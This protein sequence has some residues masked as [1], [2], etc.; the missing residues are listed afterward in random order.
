MNHYFFK[1]LLI[2]ILVSI[3]F[4]LFYKTDKNITIKIPAYTLFKPIPTELVPEKKEDKLVEPKKERTPVT[5]IFINLEKIANS[6]KVTLENVTERFIMNR[7]IIDKELEMKTIDMLTKIINNIGFIDNYHIQ[8]IDSMFVMKDDKK[9]FRNIIMFTMYD[10]YNYYTMK[11]MIDIVYLDN[12]YI[13]NYININPSSVNN[14]MNQYDMV[15][16]NQGILSNY[17]MFDENIDVRMDQYYKDNFKLIN[18]DPVYFHDTQV[19][20]AFT[21]KEHTLHYYPANVPLTDSPMFCNHSSPSW[22][23]DSLLDVPRSGD[24]VATLTASTPYPNYPYNSPASIK[25]RVDA[26]KY[27]WLYKPERGNLSSAGNHL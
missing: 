15:W 23:K 2:A 3:T 10:T 9:N 16:N 7:D 12:V 27:D 14:I 5:N 19:V 4:I 6:E 8:E 18:I 13:I 11:L 21:I 17:N 24:C 25:S 20:N 1:L 26:N 22:N